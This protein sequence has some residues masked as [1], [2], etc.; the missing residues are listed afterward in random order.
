MSE[1]KSPARETSAP[2]SS[3]PAEGR[4]HHKKRESRRK[5]CRLCADKVERVDYKDIPLLKSFIMESGKM[6]SRRITGAC[7]K[8]QRQIGKAIKRNRNLAMLPYSVR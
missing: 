3:A 5:V 2:P 4:F 1:S 8:H 7:A 6:L